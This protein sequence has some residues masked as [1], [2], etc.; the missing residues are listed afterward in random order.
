MGNVRGG[1]IAARERH[2]IRATIF[3]S[4]QHAS[5]HFHDIDSSSQNGV[6][7]SARPSSV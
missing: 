7:V 4:R 6:K 2:H 1:F 3:F 5:I